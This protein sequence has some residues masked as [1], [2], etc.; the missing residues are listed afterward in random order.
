MMCSH[1]GL[2]VSV[3]RPFVEKSKTFLI[4]KISLLKKRDLPYTLLF[5]GVRNNLVM[6]CLSLEF[7]MEQKLLLIMRS[8]GIPKR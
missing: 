6:S 3:R 1:L 5:P 4:I 2:K 8:T 7:R